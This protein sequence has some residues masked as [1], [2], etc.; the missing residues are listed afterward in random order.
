[1]P[2]RLYLRPQPRAF[3]LLTETHA[4]VFRQPGND[5]TKAS[6]SVVVAEFL[7]LDQVDTADLI[8]VPNA[9]AV[10]GVLGVTS[11]PSGEFQSRQTHQ[12]TSQI[13]P[14]SPRSS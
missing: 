10:E 8:S 14:L 2:A 3:Y 4:L 6:R 9:R 7:P 11:V 13:G 5:E 1:M 12:L